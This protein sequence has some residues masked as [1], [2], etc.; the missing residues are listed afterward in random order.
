MSGTET[1]SKYDPCLVCG[2]N[3]WIPIREGGD[4]CRPGYEKS[5]KLTRCSSCGHVMQNPI[6]ADRELAAAYAVSSDYACYRPAWKEPGWPV[7][8]ILRSWTMLRR[9]A[10]LKRHGKGH[11]LLEVGCGAGDFMV[12]AHHAGWNVRA[13]E[14]NSSMVDIIRSAFGFD[15]RV[16]E[17]ACGLWDE[18]QF[19]VV[20]FWNVLEHLQDP[21]RK[22]SVAASYLRPGGRVFLN[23]P[24][25]QA[26]EHGQWF[27]QYWAMLDL[28]R[29][30]H[31][32]DEVALSRLCGKAGL[33][34]VV[35][36]T[37]FIQS[38]W[39]YYMSSWHWANRN[40]K[41]RL[42]WLQFMA[43]AALVT[44]GLP[45]VAIQAMRRRG[46]EAFTV[47]VRH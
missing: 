34:V 1:K 6:P 21:L 8:K 39:S 26:A 17:L 13:V 32:F 42:W 23:I 16:G 46:L 2:A 4:L 29:H 35:Y 3:E 24:S 43:L 30:L 7:W 22:L 12:A 41:K 14:Y 40:G 47:A 28:P 9:V 5:F 18:G 25:R 10:L 15:V 19:D 36:E 20:A 31:F 38:A 45:Y 27:G 44:L 37:P 11:E 33:E